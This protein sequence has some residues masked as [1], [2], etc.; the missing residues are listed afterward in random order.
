[1]S[2]NCTFP[3]IFIAMDRNNG[4]PLLTFQSRVLETLCKTAFDAW[5]TTISQAFVIHIDELQYYMIKC[6]KHLTEDEFT[7]AAKFAA[8]VNVTQNAIW[9]RKQLAIQTKMEETF[10]SANH[11]RERETAEL[12][13]LLYEH[14]NVRDEWLK[15]ICENDQRPETVSDVRRVI[16]DIEEGKDNHEAEFAQCVGNCDAYFSKFIEMR[17]RSLKE[18]L[19]A[20]VKTCINSINHNVDCNISGSSECIREMSESESSRIDNFENAAG[21]FLEKLCEKIQRSLSEVGTYI[22]F[23]PQRSE[24]FEVN[25]SRRLKNLVVKLNS[26]LLTEANLLQDYLSIFPSSRAVGSRRAPSSERQERGGDSPRNGAAL[27]VRLVFS[28]GCNYS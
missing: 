2:S 22:A 16:E 18:S 7:A 21:R 12:Q 1:A 20:A 25:N 11:Y 15:H 4:V 8:E 26:D 9:R 17:E 24:E 23:V 5:N 14:V 3:I 10:E 13:K 28:I 27:L 6:A 19:I